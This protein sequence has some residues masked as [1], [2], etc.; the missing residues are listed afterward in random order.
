MTKEIEIVNAKIN[1][2]MLGL[3]DHEIMTFIVDL[4]FGGSGQGFG[5]Y[6]LDDYDKKKDKRIGSAY[7]MESIMRLL[8]VVGVSKW[9]ELKGKN[10]RVKREGGWNGRLAAIG[11]ILEDKWLNMKELYDEME[12]D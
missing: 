2:T 3:E 10:V 7:G 4:D 11:N 12:R 8:D 6:A 1:W 9:E 5:G